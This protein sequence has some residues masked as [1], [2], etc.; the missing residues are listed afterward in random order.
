LNKIIF[1]NCPGLAGVLSVKEFWQ[2]LIYNEAFLMS[3][4]SSRRSRRDGIFGRGS[5]RRSRQWRNKRRFRHITAV[6]VLLFLGGALYYL[7]QAGMMP[8]NQAAEGWYDVRRSSGVQV[9][10]PRD[11]AP[12][13]NYVE[14]WYYNGHLR[15]GAGNEYSFH[16]VVF[17]IQALGTYSVAHASMVDHQNLRHAISQRRTPGNPSSGTVDHFD[18]V[19]GG[20]SL[21]GGDGIDR[22]RFDVDASRFDLQLIQAVAPVMQGGTGIL[23]FESTGASYYYTRPRMDV[24]GTLNLDGEQRQVSGIAW[25]DHQWGDFEIFDLGWDWFALQLDDGQDIML[26]RLFDPRDGRAVL[27]SGT[28][29]ADGDLSVLDADDFTLDAVDHW[30]SPKTSRRYP[31]AWRVALPKFGVDL[32]VVPLMQDNEFDARTT[33]YMVYWEGPVRISGSHGGV[34]YVELSGYGSDNAPT[35]VT[36]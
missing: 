2:H 29:A 7:W 27:T 18:F 25:F 17:V 22:L 14:W 10:L 26:Y 24:Q 32:S 28:V 19:F 6:I 1:V 36:P 33:T 3:P 11:D 21:S 20:W 9:E 4:Q 23:D 34:G 30:R 31:M 8:V 35:P 13:D 12:H 16:Y 15:D 5:L